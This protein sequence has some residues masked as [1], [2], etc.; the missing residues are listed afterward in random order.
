MR[1]IIICIGLILLF[2]KCVF[3]SSV[4]IHGATD[5]TYIN[6]HSA[7]D[8]QNWNSETSP[9]SGTYSKQLSLTNCNARGDGVHDLVIKFDITPYLGQTIQSATINLY[10]VVPAWTYS[11]DLYYKAINLSYFNSAWSEDTITWNNAPSST[12]VKTMTIGNGDS[13]F[14]CWV[15]IDITEIANLWLSGAVDNNGVRMHVNQIVVS[16]FWTFQ[17]S[18]ESTNVPVLTLNFDDPEPAAV[19][20]PATIVLLTLS[21]VGL[22]RRKMLR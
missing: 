16:N 6:N 2:T 7:H 20:E 9:Y 21:A 18:E 11:V 5:D 15:S 4:E 13:Y 22:I 14:N 8:D 12:F 1:N 19:P 17:R 3:A 10:R